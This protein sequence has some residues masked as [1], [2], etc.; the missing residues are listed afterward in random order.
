MRGIPL[1]VSGSQFGLS[2]SSAP[3][4]QLKRP[5]VAGEV[6]VCLVATRLSSNQMAQFTQSLPSD[7]ISAFS[8][9][10]L[11]ELEDKFH[12]FDVSGDGS[13]S[14]EEFHRALVNIG[15]E[16][17][18]EKTR[19]IMKTIDIDNSGSLNFCE[20]VR[21]VHLIRTKDRT[22]GRGQFVLKRT[23][24]SFAETLHGDGGASHIIP[25]SERVRALWV[26][27]PHSPSQLAFSAHINNCLENDPHANRHLPLGLENSQDLYQK[28]DDG[29]IYWF[30]SLHSH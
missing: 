2:Q 16:I 28:T 18:E 24:T 11:R 22:D 26:F 30:L 29:L 13:I 20:F 4:Q 15:E 23:V 3:L 25:D 9:A 8:P 19:E 5:D 7:L 27:S 1:T 21:F 6:D 12:E 14:L 17:S 10:A